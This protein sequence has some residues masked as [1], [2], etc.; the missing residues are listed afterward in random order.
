MLKYFG[1]LSFM[2][3]VAG[4]ASTTPETTTAEIDVEAQKTRW[5]MEGRGPEWKVSIND[6]RFHGSFPGRYEGRVMTWDV[7]EKGNITYLN[8]ANKAAS[9]VL[10]EKACTV[11]GK[12]FTHTAVVKINKQTFTGCAKH[13][14]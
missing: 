10:T 3:F 2:V 12:E 13:K 6:Q 14:S 7:S 1:L 11:A 4:C 5:D 8:A 9:I